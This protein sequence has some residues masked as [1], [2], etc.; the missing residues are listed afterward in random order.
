MRNIEFGQCLLL[1]ILHKRGMN[2]VDLSKLTGIS[3]S[4]ISLYISGKRKMSLLTAV[5]ISRVLK[6]HAEDLY[7]WKEK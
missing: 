7:I 2:Q 4:E 6:V 1:N 5:K 3:E